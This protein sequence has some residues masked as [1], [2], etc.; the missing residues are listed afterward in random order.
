[1]PSGHWGEHPSVRVPGDAI[2]LGKEPGTRGDGDAPE[3]CKD[4]KAAHQPLATRGVQPHP[5]RLVGYA[6]TSIA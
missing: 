4:S 3:G 6:E 1:M 5:G 2:P